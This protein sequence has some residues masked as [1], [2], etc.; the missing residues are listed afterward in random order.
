MKNEEFASAFSFQCSMV[1]V[2]CSMFNGQCSM[3]NEKSRK[4]ETR[5]PDPHVPN[6]V[7]YQLRYFPFHALK[8]CLGARATKSGSLKT[9]AKV[10]KKEKRGKRKSKNC[11]QMQEKYTFLPNFCLFA[12]AVQFFALPLHSQTQRREQKHRMVP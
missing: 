4:E 7:R 11:M 6:V 12:C 9:G 3:V 5:T 8:A 10:R 2:Q 1:N